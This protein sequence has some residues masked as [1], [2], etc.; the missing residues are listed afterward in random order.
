MSAR[1]GAARVMFGISI[2]LPFAVHAQ[3]PELVQVPR[4]TSRDSVTLPASR[5]Y[6]AGGLH[7]FFLGDNYRDIWGRPIKAPVID[8]QT[9]AGGLKATRIG[10]GKQTRSL[11]F[12]SA[13]GRQFVF[14]PLYKSLLD[15]PEIFENTIIWDAIMDARSASHPT[16]PLSATPIL[17]AAGVLHSPAVLAAMPDDPALGEFR[18]EFAGVLGTIEETP[19][20]PATGTGWAGAIEVIDSEAL[21][22]RID[23]SAAGNTVDARSFLKAVLADMLINDND[24][25]AG[26]W[27]WARFERG[28]HWVPIPRDRDKVFID[29][30]GALLAIARKTEPTLVAYDSIYPRGTALFDNAFEF[31]R[32]L[33][34]GI[35]RSVWDSTA[36]TLSLL[37]TDRVLEESLGLMPPEYGESSRE[38]LATLKARRS[39][40]P[41]AALDYYAD[42]SEVADLHASDADERASVVRSADGIV[43]VSISDLAGNRYYDR[44]FNSAETKEIRLYLHG[45]DDAASVTGQVSSSIPL[46]IIGGNGNNTLSDNSTVGGSGG[47]ARLYDV[48]NTTGVEYE[49][50]GF[51]KENDEP[52]LPFNR[53]PWSRTYG[54][55]R[56][57]QRDHG[58]TAGPIFGLKTG[59]GL[60]LVPKIGYQITRYGFRSVPYRNRRKFELGYSTAIR[61]FDVGLY[62]DDRREASNVHVMSE[63][64]M[65]QLEVVEFRGFGNDVADTGGEFFDVRQRQWRFNP[66]IGYAFGP[67]SDV[68]LGPVVRYTVT[69]STH[70]RF[71]SEQRPYGFARFGQAGLLLKLYHDTRMAPDTGRNRGGVDFK[72]RITPPVWGTLNIEAGAYPKIWDVQESYQD[73]FGVATA[74]LTFPF[75]TRPV[76]ALRAGGQKL[77]GDFPYFDAAFIGGSRSLRTEHRQ[78]YAGDA[79][80]FGT[81]ELRVPIAEFPLILPWNFGV[82]GFVD[83]ARVYVDG[84]SPGGWHRGM[85]GGFWLGVVNPGTGITV[86]ATNNSERRVLVSLG[87]AF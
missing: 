28:G 87:F 51:R 55:L 84:E 22:K 80:L 26:N 63:T 17:R 79:S 36:R 9:F 70:N 35:D 83:M 39:R 25:H 72:G 56:Q 69:D 59:H 5:K 60:G 1:R 42:L 65:T 2:L 3:R 78:R 11:R 67:A 57:P 48:G 75:A 50:E 41:A 30:Q 66:S 77:F 7:R 44:R 16:A 37:F 40:L 19:D 47:K 68:S 54:Y 74:Y 31:E 62:T 53:V 73:V 43:D 76:L 32:R 85:G 81:T 6:D 14:R 29:Y 82:L 20:V 15:L 71:I 49:P 34:S 46:R 18:K 86:M 13:D 33:L 24:R 52:A 27:R 64:R 8:L 12:E 10:G 23:S 4:I 38:I 21:L 58:T 61:G 45:G